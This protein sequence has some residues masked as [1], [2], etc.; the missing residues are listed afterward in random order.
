MGVDDGILGSSCLNGMKTFFFLTVCINDDMSVDRV[1]VCVRA[2]ITGR[3]EELWV[4]FCVQINSI[5]NLMDFR[6]EHVC[7]S[8]R[9]KPQLHAPICSLLPTPSGG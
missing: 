6:A 3:M 5:F 4:I 9:I 1:C 2:T 7:V 8:V